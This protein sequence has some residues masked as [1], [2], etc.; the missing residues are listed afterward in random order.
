MDLLERAISGDRAAL[1]ELLYSS[2]HEL[3]SFVSRHLP[4]RIQDVVSV[5][6]ILQET[7]RVAFR[8]IGQFEPRGD[9]A[10]LA[11]LRTIAQRRVQDA[12]KAED[13]KKRGGDHHRIRQ[14][15]PAFS[16]DSIANLLEIIATD[17]STPV[18]RASRNEALYLMNV[19]L[20]ELPDHYREALRL[21]FMEGLSYAEI[22][23]RMGR[24]ARSVQ[25][26]LIRAKERLRELLGS[27]SAY[28]SS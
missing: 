26:L 18:R 7:F 6:D 3:S 12:I 1:G 24:S 5:D 15:S 19:A 23:E 2:A 10:F 21:Q 28:L 11:W 25:S 14:A 9:G 13:R 27:A 20:A 4:Q 17:S 16:T 22:G 8:D